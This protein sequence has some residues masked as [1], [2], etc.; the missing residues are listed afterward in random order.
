MDDVTKE[1]IYHLIVLGAFLITWYDYEIAAPRR[2]RKFI[3]EMNKQQYKKIAK[4][5]SDPKWQETMK[6]CF[7]LHK[8]K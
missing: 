6:K 2:Y 3:D 5:M 4:I 7:E 1:L 8:K